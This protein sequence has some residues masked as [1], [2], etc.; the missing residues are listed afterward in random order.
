MAIVV[1]LPVVNV[2]RQYLPTA[3]SA[4]HYT[5]DFIARFCG[6]ASLHDIAAPP[7]CAVACY[8]Y[9]IN[10]PKKYDFQ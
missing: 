8:D 10:K 5:S 7:D 4:Q 3:D 1:N 2:R 9:R 6:T